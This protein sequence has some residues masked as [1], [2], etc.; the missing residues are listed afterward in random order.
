M[1]T[2]ATLS[3]TAACLCPSLSHISLSHSSQLST[4]YSSLGTV[5]E[6]HQLILASE[7]AQDTGVRGT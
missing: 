3:S 6:L 7:V 4:L 5:T 1:G 2:H